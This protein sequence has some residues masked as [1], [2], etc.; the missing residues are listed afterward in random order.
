MLFHPL[1]PLQPVERQDAV[2]EPD[3]GGVEHDMH[4]FPAARQLVHETKIL[5]AD[6]GLRCQRYNELFV[7]AVKTP[8]FS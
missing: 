2:P 3:V 8:V 5:D 6:G 4:A 1:V 7:R